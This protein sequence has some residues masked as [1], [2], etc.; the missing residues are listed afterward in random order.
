MDYGGLE[1]R[2]ASSREVGVHQLLAENKS[3]MPP[4]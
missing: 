2:K 1:K 3:M 4:A